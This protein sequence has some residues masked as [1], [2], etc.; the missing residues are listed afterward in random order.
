VVVKVKIL[1]FDERKKEK[2]VLLFFLPSFDQEIF[3]GAVSGLRQSSPSSFPSSNEIT[4]KQLF[5]SALEVHY[6]FKNDGRRRSATPRTRPS[7]EERTV[8]G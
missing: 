6:I 1:F 8:G 4:K 2:K 7:E 5:F 3:R